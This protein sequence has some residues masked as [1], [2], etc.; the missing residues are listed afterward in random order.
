MSQTP[1][2]YVIDDDDAVRDSIRLLLEI[3]GFAVRSYASGA[4]FLRE[5]PSQR[6]SCLLVDLD[7]P[8]MNG[9]DLLD[10]LRQRGKTIPAI[11]MTGGVTPT[12]RSD[13]KRVGVQLLEKPFHAQELMGCIEAALGRYQA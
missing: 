10:Q 5:A 8:G 12:V 6:N 1:T 9:F 4:G 7:M 3:T 2:V 13:A 11:I